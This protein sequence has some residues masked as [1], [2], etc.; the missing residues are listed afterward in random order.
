MDLSVVIDALPRLWQA[1]IVT[2]QL[3]VASIA[4]ATVLGVVLSILSWSGGLVTRAVLAAFSWVMRCV[5][6]LIILF[7]AYYGLPQLNIDLPPFVAAVAGL[8]LQGG[9]YMMEIFRSGIQSVP[10]GQFDAA[11][12]LG[13]QP[14]RSW[15]QLIG[16]QALRISLPGYTSDAV[17]I[18]KGTSVASIITVI[19]LTGASNSIIGVTYKAVEVLIPVAIVYALLSSVL[20][21][22]QHL[23]ERTLDPAT[24]SVRRLERLDN[25]AERQLA[26]ANA[27]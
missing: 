3:S 7:I 23:L 11:R 9:A 15:L 18:L 22:L 2:I 14:R 20:I 10:S 16:P 26:R 27:A 21:L 24:R 4:L 17:K 13:V 5:P 12:A 19:E 8:G 1:V 6:A 25:R